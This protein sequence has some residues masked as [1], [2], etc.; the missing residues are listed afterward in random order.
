M[1][2]PMTESIRLSQDTEKI[3]RNCSSS[4]LIW[5]S[6]VKYF[7]PVFLGSSHL[8][9]T[10]STNKFKP[11]ILY[12]SSKK[13]KGLIKNYYLSRSPLKKMKLGSDPG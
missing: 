6:R 8:G 7:P 1:D 2:S 11:L 10:P 12:F 5:Y 9:L 3:G 13:L 4:S